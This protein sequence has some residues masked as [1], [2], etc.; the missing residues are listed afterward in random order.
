M[1]QVTLNVR[2]DSEV[3]NELSNLCDELGFSVSTAVNIFARAMLRKRGIPFEVVADEPNEVTKRALEESMGGKNLVGP[4]H[5]V[6]EFME[7]LNAE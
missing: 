3:K 1:G 5:S 7:S 6:E 4:F 2:I